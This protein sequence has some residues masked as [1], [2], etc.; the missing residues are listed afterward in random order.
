MNQESCKD[1]AESPS[2]GSAAP[3]RRG[4]VPMKVCSEEDIV[5]VEWT[6]ERC[7]LSLAFKNLRTTG[8]EVMLAECLAGFKLSANNWP[9]H[10]IFTVTSAGSDGS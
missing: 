1:A 9:V 8:D 2:I 7:D 5:V 6:I 10:V 4:H 3:A